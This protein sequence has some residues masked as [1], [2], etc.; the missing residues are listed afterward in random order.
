[1]TCDVC[2]DDASDDTL[3][4]RTCSDDVVMFLSGYDSGRVC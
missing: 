4:L 1:M 3:G 2:R